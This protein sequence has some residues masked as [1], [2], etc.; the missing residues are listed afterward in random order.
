MGNVEITISRHNPHIDPHLAIWGW[1][2]PGYLFLGGI[3]AGIL[4]LSGI[5]YLLKKEEE[6][7]F[8]VRI[9]PIVAPIALSIGML[10]LFLDLEH[11]L[12]TWRLYTTFQ[13]TSPMSWGSWALILIFPSS[14]LFALIQLEESSRNFIQEKLHTF[15]L[16]FLAKPAEQ[17]FVLADKFRPYTKALAW[18]NI[19]MGGFIGIYTGILISSFVARPFW[20]TSILGILFLASGIS[21]ASAVMI[22]GT[23]SKVEE[24]IMIKIDVAFLL[25]ELFVLIQIFIGF[26]TSSYYHNLAGG[27]IFGGDFTGY[28]WMLVVLQGILF[29]LFME[30]LELKNIFHFKLIT[31]FSV[32]I[33]GLL[34]RILFVYIG[35]NSYVELNL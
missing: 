7:P 27:L 33:G 18:I 35:Q 2:I 16:S 22:L 6:V 25:F 17:V 34:L 23:K 29:P 5:F 26:F 11:K 28:F 30:V 12:F 13:W 8:T 3:T 32:L 1:E 10:F 14:I 31:P 20:N 21:S 19:V 4:V 15:K 24:H 9:A